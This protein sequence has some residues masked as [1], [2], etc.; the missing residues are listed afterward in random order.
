MMVGNISE[1]SFMSRGWQMSAQIPNFE[2]VGHDTEVCWYLKY[3]I[4]LKK[5]INLYTTLLITHGLKAIK[6]T[7]SAILLF[8]YK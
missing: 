8:N 3:G 4:F 7:D 1:D 6:I 5:K 2:T